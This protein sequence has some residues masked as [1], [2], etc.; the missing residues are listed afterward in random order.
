MA[1][2][3][4]IYYMF[5]QGL[6]VD[7]KPILQARK[8]VWSIATAR[9]L[10]PL[11]LG[12]LL[13]KTLTPNSR[14]LKATTYGPFFWG[15]TLTTTNFAELA[16]VLANAKLL[17]SDIGRT[18][19]SASVINDLISS[20]LLLITVA[21]ISDGKLYTVLSTLTLIILCV[22]GLRPVLSWMVRNTSFFDE[23]YDMD[24]Q[25]CFIMGGVLLFGF[26]SDAFGSHSILG[27]FMLG[28]ILP[29][30]ELK[31]AITEKVKDFV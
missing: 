2:L 30:G 28:A 23:K 24:S 12:Y 4:L 3:G 11:P 16:R 9:I 10:V 6:E 13:H 8:K 31:T 25:I 7:F 18:A 29:K 21:I 27:A 20:V 14:P 5:L 19:L 26:I 22:Y 1:N 15:I 17:H